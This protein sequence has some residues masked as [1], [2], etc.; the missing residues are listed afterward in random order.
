MD[1]SPSL[2]T[3]DHDLLIRISV[4]Q[5]AMHEEMRQ[6]NTTHTM[7]IAKLEARVG[8]LET[9]AEVNKGSAETRNQS[10]RNIYEMVGLAAAILT[11]VATY[12]LGKGR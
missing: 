11:A 8:V 5:E 1:T 4:T 7:Q 10:R 9:F 12:M 6:S 2:S 3:S